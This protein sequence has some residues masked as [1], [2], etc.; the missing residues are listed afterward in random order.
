MS[1]VA[2]LPA[3]RRLDDATLEGLLVQREAMV[4]RLTERLVAGAGQG[5][6]HHVLLVGPTGS[7]TS[8]L[9]EC[10]ARRVD[11]ARVAGLQVVRLPEI[12]GRLASWPQLLRALVEA[13]E[14]D[15]PAGE[16]DDLAALD[17]ESREAV[18]L[19][20]WREAITG[21]GLLVVLED[22]AGLFHALGEPGQH[23]LRGFLQTEAGCSLIATTARVFPAIV[24]RDA[25]CFGLFATT[26][27]DSLED[28]ALMELVTRRVARL[29]GEVPTDASASVP[30]L[31]PL[32]GRWPGPWA[33]LAEGLAAG[34]ELPAAVE[35]VVAAER[36]ASVA[37]L[38][39]L[40][41]QQRMLV[42]RLADVGGALPVKALARDGWLSEQTAARQLGELRVAGWVQGERVGRETWYEL[43][44]PLVR[45]A[46]RLDGPDD[47]ARL[48]AAVGWLLDAGPT[49]DAGMAD[50][51]RAAADVDAVTAE[52]L[53]R[54]DGDDA[55]ALA[56]SVL[57]SLHGLVRRDVSDVAVETWT[58][59]WQAVA[60][61]R[62]E[63]AP[64]ARWVAVA[65]A[66][67]DDEDPRQLLGLPAEQ[68]DLVR[69]ALA[70]AEATV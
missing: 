50:A 58:A 16:A 64:L 34:L 49:D 59:A 53:A 19:H 32:L 43:S 26:Y 63:L 37:R 18:L 42:L 33:H 4:A 44:D 21:R 51:L 23:G 3:P 67:R 55:A 57:G 70:R 29:G 8:H 54:A 62:P 69:S 60:A 66:A 65:R 10:V 1:A 20:R 9:A 38:A 35:H 41:P 31:V 48:R 17:D 45:Q 2:P 52:L 15:A 40:S 47:A 61:R 6:R 12:G 13:A 22:L 39:R 28:E 5:E 56:R 24:E 7:G 68:R 25:P 46:L 11:A 36:R 30:A 14:G 27:L